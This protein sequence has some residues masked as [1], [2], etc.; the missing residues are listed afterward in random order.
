MTDFV[1]PGSTYSKE[2]SFH[3]LE[4]LMNLFEN[5]KG[6]KWKKQ[7]NISKN[8]VLLTDLRFLLPF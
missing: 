4:G 2:K 3:L 8:G 7:L 5:L 1:M 6:Q